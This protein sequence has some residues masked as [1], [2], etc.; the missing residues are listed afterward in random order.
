MTTTTT[1]TNTRNLFSSTP[2]SFNLT[3]R[4]AAVARIENTLNAESLGDLGT[5]NYVVAANEDGTFTPVVILKSN[6]RWIAPALGEK[7]IAVAG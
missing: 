2:I 1:T 7:G 3:T 4:S 5:F 6:Q